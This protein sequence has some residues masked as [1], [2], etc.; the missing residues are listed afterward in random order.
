M[1][2]L[3]GALFSSWQPV[4]TEHR[5]PGVRGNFYGQ[6]FA[7][8]FIGTKGKFQVGELST[9][10]PHIIAYAGYNDGTLSKVALIDLRFYNST[11]KG[12]RLTSTVKLTGLGGAKSVTVQKLDAAGAEVQDGITWQGEE[13]SFA[14]HGLPKKVKNDT[15]TVSVT[16]GA[17]TVTIQASQALMVVV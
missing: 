11:T 7:A 14:N 2:Q 17:A 10:N 1:Q 13:W 3:T 16:G 15:Q 12:K 9:G 5:S 6:V 8:D 4:P